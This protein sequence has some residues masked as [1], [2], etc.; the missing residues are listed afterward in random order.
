MTAYATAAEVR[1]QMNKSGTEDDTILDALTLATSRA[2][3]NFTNRPAGAYKALT[4]ATAE[5]YPSSGKAHLRIE[6]CVQITLVETR[7][8]AN[9]AYSAWEAGWWVAYT[10]DTERPKFGKTPITG[11]MCTDVKYRLFPAKSKLPMVR[12]TAKWGYA[13]NVPDPIKQACITMTARWYKRGEGAWAD[14][15]A[16]GNFGILM[17]K[18]ALDP[19]VQMML[20]MGRYI[21]P[22]IG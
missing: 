6:E 19:D 8:E 5:E 11:V 21:R 14:A 10:G 1:A 2:I 22:A 7:N 9:G 20:R 18:Q 15:L 12:I 3:D 16:D 4:T 17:Y 13:V